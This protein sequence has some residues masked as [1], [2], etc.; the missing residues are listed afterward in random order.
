MSTRRAARFRGRP[1]ADSF[2]RRARQPA[3]DH[4][5]WKSNS[6]DCELRLFH[7][8]ILL[9]V[10]SVTVTTSV[11]VPL[12]N[13]SLTLRLSWSSLKVV[14]VVVLLTLIGVTTTWPFEF[15]TATVTE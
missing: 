4:W 13:P 14:A 6:G 9:F 1:P 15:S 7:P 2:L 8:P 3:R 10:N 12:D 5:P 11:Y